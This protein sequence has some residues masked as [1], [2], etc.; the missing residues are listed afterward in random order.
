MNAFIPAHLADIQTYPKDIIHSFENG[1]FAVSIV[2]INLPH[3]SA[4]KYVNVNAL[5]MALRCDPDLASLLRDKIHLIFQVLF[6]CTGCDYIS[7]FKSIGK[8]TFLNVFYQHAE[9][10]TGK[11]MYG[12]LSDT[13]NTDRA[14]GF[15]SFL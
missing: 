8:T 7:F 14:I 2:Q 3:D 1:G 15:Y 11:E 5:Y 10:I 9:F 12:M 6:I 13:S 4:Q